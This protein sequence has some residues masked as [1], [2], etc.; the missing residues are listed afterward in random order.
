[1]EKKKAY[2][3]PS[4]ESETFVPNTYVAACE[5]GVTYWFKCDAGPESGWNEVWVESNGVPGLQT[6]RSGR[7]PADTRRTS[8]YHACGTEHE[9]RGDENFLDGYVVVDH[10]WDADEVIPAL[11]WTNH[12]TNTHC[13]TQLHPEEWEVA[14]S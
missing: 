7:T 3:K 5:S 6:R 10:G 9:V 14:K 2:V 11:I 12:N 8:T 13:T 4:M 1:M